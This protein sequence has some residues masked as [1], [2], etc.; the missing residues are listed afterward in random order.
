MAT[1]AV[2]RIGLPH[3]LHMGPEMITPG[4]R[5]TLVSFPRL[6]HHGRSLPHL[7]LSCSAGRCPGAVKT[8]VPPLPRIQGVTVQ[9]AA[10]SVFRPLQSPA[11]GLGA[12]LTILSQSTI[13]FTTGNH[14][15][16]GIRFM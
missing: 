5:R 4:S 11:S 1:L 13:S 2:T 10:V 16:M 15:A 8:I 6:Y 7:S 14:R 12:S 3:V 9:V